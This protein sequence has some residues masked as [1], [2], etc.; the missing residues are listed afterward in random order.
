MIERMP[1][2]VTLL[3]VP[4]SVDV[5]LRLRRVR[6][7]RRRRTSS[8]DATAHLI[9]LLG[10]EAGLRC[11]EMIALEWR[12]VDL[13]KRQTLRPAVRLERPGDDAERRTA[14][15]RAAHRS[16]SR[17]R[18][19]IIGICGVPSVLCQ[20]DGTAADAADGAGPRCCGRR[21]E[22]SCRRTACTSC[23]TRSVRTWR[24]AARRRRAIQELAGHRGSRHDA[25]LHAPESG[26]ARQRDSAAGSAV[27]SVQ[28]FGDI[29]ETGRVSEEKING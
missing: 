12:D 28:S 14:A 13:G 23:G 9:V 15:V 7:A 26:G 18:S 22:R 17:R 5:V 19:A 6:A 8:I 24:C 16:D 27:W 20:D 1:C 4:K 2:T 25:A 21:V 11:G 10:G 29:L 3:P